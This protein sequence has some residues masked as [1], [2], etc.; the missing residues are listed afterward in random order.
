MRSRTPSLKPTLCISG[1]PNYPPVGLQVF[2]SDGVS[3]PEENIAAAREKGLHGFAIMGNNSGSPSPRAL[4]KN[5]P[6]LLLHEATSSLDS[7]SE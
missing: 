1:R 7:E 6:I 2:F 4:L 5:A 3:S